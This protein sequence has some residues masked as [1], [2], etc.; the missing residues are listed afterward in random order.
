MAPENFAERVKGV[1]LQLGLSQKV[2]AHELDMSFSTIN[3][4]ENGKT[5]PFTLARKQFEA[6][7]VRHL[8]GRT[9]GEHGSV[10]W[11][12]AQTDGGSAGLDCKSPHSPTPRY[13]LT[14]KGHCWLQHHADE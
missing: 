4:L 3:C 1:R 11:S 8:L 14:G 7:C 13:R 10:C 6:F 9:V 12:C 2:L 5:V